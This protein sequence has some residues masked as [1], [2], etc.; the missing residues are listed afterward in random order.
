MWVVAR[1]TQDMIAIPDFSAG[2]MENWGLVTYREAWSLQGPIL[3]D[4]G[5]SR[6]ADCTGI[7]LNM[8]AGFTKGGI[9]L[10]TRVP[11]QICSLAED[12]PLHIYIYIYCLLKARLLATSIKLLPP[13]DFFPFPLYWHACKSMLCAE[14]VHS[15]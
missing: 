5:D 4:L 15:Q 10:P 3:V 8:M 13:V 11:V 14:D 6:E 2:A 1:P 7:L 9:Q 12:R